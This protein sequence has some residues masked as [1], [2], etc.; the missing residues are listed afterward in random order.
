MLHDSDIYLRSTDGSLVG[1]YLRLYQ[2]RSYL[3]YYSMLQG[4]TDQSRL[5]TEVR[6]TGESATSD[7]L[8]MSVLHPTLPNCP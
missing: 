7:L 4:R 1:M 3:A 2:L 6:L 5:C 8:M